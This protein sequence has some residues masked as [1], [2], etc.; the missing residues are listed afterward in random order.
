MPTTLRV[1]ALGAT[2]L[3]A[4]ACHHGTKLTPLAVRATVAG[5]VMDAESHE[6]LA[7]VTVNLVPVGENRKYTSG[8]QGTTEGSGDFWLDV[9]PGG[10]YELRVIRLG[11]KTWSQHV[12]LST[13]TQYK[14]AIVMNRLSPQCVPKVV[15][16]ATVAC[17]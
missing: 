8:A 2:T 6:P 4:L 13:S 1:A 15:G 11:Y 16:R 7:A 14:F 10:D 5:K 3:L 9:V 17:P 12:T